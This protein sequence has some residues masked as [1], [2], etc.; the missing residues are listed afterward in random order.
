MLLSH[1][2]YSLLEDLYDRPRRLTHGF[3]IGF[4]MYIWNAAK[5]FTSRPRIYF[6]FWKFRQVRAKAIYYRPV[7]SITFCNLSRKSRGIEDK[8]SLL[9]LISLR[10]N[11]RKDIAQLS[12]QKEIVYGCNESNRSIG[13]QQKE[14]KR[15]IMIS[16][17]R[18]IFHAKEW[19]FTT[20]IM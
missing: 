3:Q 18:F 8:K 10:V 16:L 9:N 17:R 20:V 6:F 11:N 5:I 13:S 7:L 15:T 1:D 4:Q 19:Y 2:N 14:K 12:I